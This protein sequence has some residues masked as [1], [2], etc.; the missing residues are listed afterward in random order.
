MKI[1]KETVC[2]TYFF[3]TLIPN[4]MQYF[5]IIEVVLSEKYKANDRRI[6]YNLYKYAGTGYGE[7]PTF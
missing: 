6:D 2:F 4:S 5:N 1:Q 3:L 7:S